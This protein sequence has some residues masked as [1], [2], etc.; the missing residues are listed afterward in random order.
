[1]HPLP[2]ERDEDVAHLSASVDIR[3]KLFVRRDL[4]CSLTGRFVGAAEYLFSVASSS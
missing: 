1:M 2:V 4:S 3:Y